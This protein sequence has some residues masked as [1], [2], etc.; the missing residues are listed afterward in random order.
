MNTPAH[1][2][3]DDELL[4]WVEGRL[5]AARTAALEAAMREDPGLAAAMGAWR[6]HQEALSRHPGS[7]GTGV[8]ARPAD[9]AR[10][11]AA[12]T[13]WRIAAAV[14]I[15]G[16]AALGFQAGRG[17]V[18]DE[19]VRTAGTATGGTG[20]PVAPDRTA[21]AATGGTGT[22][23]DARQT[24]GV[25]TGGTGAPSPGPA[26]TTAADPSVPPGFVRAAAVAHRV[27]VPEVRHPV[28]VSGDERGHLVAWL[29]KRLGTQL[30]A[31]DLTGEG[32]ELVGGRLLPGER[33]P[34]AQFM[35]QD[36]QGVRITLYASRG[37]GEP[38]TT[39]FR[40]EQAG[41]VQSFYWIDR[42]L[43]YVLTGELPRE[44]LSRV[45]TEVY[46]ALEAVPR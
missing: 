23:V 21:G 7:G 20:A 10:P 19:P 8:P 32:F 6:A 45:A 4:R 29:S 18:P 37:E 38:A 44:R 25:A 26:H 28:E 16:A 5:D 30:A 39:A 31:P 46:R 27:Y 13:P 2:F 42:G 17:S 11:S 33:G 12:K 15:A 14:A 1:G 24:A 43:G 41:A 3:S 36:A 35:Y 9:A 22:P 34:S 40:F